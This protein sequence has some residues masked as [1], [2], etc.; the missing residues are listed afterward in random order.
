M[1]TPALDFYYVDP[2]YVSYLQ[3]AETAVHGSSH[4]PNVVYAN[5]DKFMFGSVL[6]I[7]GVKYFVPVSSKTNK[8]SSYNLQ[9]TVPSDRVK[10]KG[11]LRF[12][13]MIPV[14]DAALT[15]LNIRSI[16][17]PGEQ[18][19]IAKERAFCFRNQTKILR[20]AERTH[21]HVVAR[22]NPALVSNSC[23]FPLL[24]NAYLKY[25]ISHSISV[26][27][28]DRKRILQ[29]NGLGNGNTL[30]AFFTKD[31]IQYRAISPDEAKLVASQSD[32][33]H[34]IRKGEKGLI[35]QHLISDTT[36]VKRLLEPAQSTLTLK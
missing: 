29:R 24:E 11:T 32:L 14:P 18:Q 16:A 1:P 17:S 33:L 20:L 21:K 25:C 36:L 26:P 9:I 22:S 7:D 5:R 28:E 35:L 30:S 3:S 31:E 27:L 12:P 2:A 23:D 6:Q 34:V 19:L 13:Y 8:S 4:V 10:V 15:R